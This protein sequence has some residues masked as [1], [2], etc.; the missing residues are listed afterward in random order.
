MSVHAPSLVRSEPERRHF[1][2]RDEKEARSI[3]PPD[4]YFDGASRAGNFE[5]KKDVGGDAYMMS[6]RGLGK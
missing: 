1:P 4:I 5:D 6:A 3:A 2:R